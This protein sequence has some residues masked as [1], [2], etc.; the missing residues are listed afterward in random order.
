VPV[1]F[2][3]RGADEGDWEVT[4]RV[5]LCPAPGSVVVLDGARRILLRGAG[6]ELLPG[7]LVR[8]RAVVDP[9]P[10]E[11]DEARGTRG[12]IYRAVDV[13][14]VFRPTRSPWTWNT[15]TGALDS[16]GVGERLRRRAVIAE[17]LRGYFRAE[18][19]LEVE[20]PVMAR[21]PG[22]DLHLHAFGVQY[23]ESPVAGVDQSGLFPSSRP[24]SGEPVAYL[25]TSPEYHMKRLLVG[26]VAKCFQL[27]RCF[28]A[29]EL[30][31]RHEPEF[32][33]L[34]WYRAWAPV[35][36]MLRDT[37]AV[38][39]A[40]AAAGPT[41]G[42][43]SVGGAVVSLAEPFERLTVRE[44]FARYAPAAGDP[45]ALAEKDEDRFFGVLVERIEPRLGMERPT[46]LTRYPARL[47]S[48]SRLAEDDPSVCE[49]FELYVHGIELCNGFL[50]L[51]DPVEQRARLQRD[52]RER[53]E[54]GLPVY[55]IDE[56]FLS[57]LEEGMPPSVGNALGVDRLI[58]LVLGQGSIADVMA[59]PDRRR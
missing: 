19:F 18:G 15:E 41:P 27:A 33:M 10:A 28:R 58:A 21:S 43:L 6:A 13:E 8:A 32:T 35:A 5:L 38:V 14:R 2:T 9:L 37:E 11:G 31:R 44:A 30:G 26:G 40:A 17:A 52:Q 45:I 46:F 16:D 25:I 20:T 54:R 50:E 29:G 57:A 39:R 48:L 23:P 42:A 7:D 12:P 53:A 59:F 49:R 47:A 22:L 1:E 24:P 34:E 51:T 55:P 4:G 36:A 3:G 56:R